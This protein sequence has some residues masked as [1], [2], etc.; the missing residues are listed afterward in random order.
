LKERQGE[1]KP[2]FLSVEEAL[3]APRLD[4]ESGGST[5]ACVMHGHVRRLTKLE[6]SLLLPNLLK[7]LM[8]GLFLHQI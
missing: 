2:A 8:E 3:T 6:A 5:D 4:R 1:R 7:S